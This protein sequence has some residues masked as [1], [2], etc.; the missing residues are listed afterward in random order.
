MAVGSFIREPTEPAQD[1]VDFETMLAFKGNKQD[2]YVADI[3]ALVHQFMCSEREIL[4]QLFLPNSDL[5]TPVSSQAM[6]L[7]EPT[8]ETDLDVVIQTNLGRIFEGTFRPINT[9]IERILGEEHSADSAYKLANP[10]QFYSRLIEKVLSS[11]KVISNANSPAMTRRG[12]SESGT[13]H[14]PAQ[15]RPH[16][17]VLLYNLTKQAFRLFYDVLN[18]QASGLL[19]LPQTPDEDLSVPPVVKS[20]V[21]E[22]KALMTSYDSGLILPLSP[23][24]DSGHMVLVEAQDRESGFQPILV[25]IVDPLIQLCSICADR[26]DSEFSRHIFM[27]NCLHYIYTALSYFISITKKRCDLLD[28][29][30]D[31]LVEHAASKEVRYYPA[32]Y[33][34]NPLVV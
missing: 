6:I 11:R 25:A 15:S 19:R 32:L 12:S 28:I 17:L 4:E 26:L 1:E 5:D 23:S 20:V 2:W 3:L 21:A 16:F 29:Q 33:R 7:P 10:V 8:F 34:V 22:L 14:V 13:G 24:T 30:M 31:V 9:R 27:L 18:Q